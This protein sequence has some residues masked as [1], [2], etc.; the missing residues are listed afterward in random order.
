[1]KGLEHSIS[2]TRWSLV[3]TDTQR[4]VLSGL[5]RKRNLRSKIWWFTEFC[6]SHYVSHFAAFF[7]V[8]RTKISVAKSCSEF[9]NVA[10]V[11]ILVR[12]KSIK[13]GM[14]CLKKSYKVTSKRGCDPRSSLPF[15]R[16]RRLSYEVHRC[17]LIRRI[18]VNDPSAGSPT[19]TLL[20]LLLPLNDQVWSPSRM[21]TEVSN[22]A[23][24]SRELTKPFNR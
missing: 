7:I 8:T 9:R 17:L 22:R 20:R 13:F 14:G 23:Q 19:E 15:Y 24:Q 10:R 6:N 3:R 11:S 1:M 5:S 2:H 21:R 16:S 4:G 12:L 18:R